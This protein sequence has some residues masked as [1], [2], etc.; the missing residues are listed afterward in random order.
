[1]AGFGISAVK[2]SDP[3]NIVLVSLSYII[4]GL[5]ILSKEDSAL[6]IL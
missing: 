6:E 1:V 4:K 2:P 3:A 5:N